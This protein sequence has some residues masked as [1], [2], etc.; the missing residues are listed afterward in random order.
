MEPSAKVSEKQLYE[1]WE[2]HSFNDKLTT[3]TGEKIT[4]ID[5]GIFDPDLSGPDFKNARIRIGNLMY[6]G[7]IE[8]DTNYNGWKAHGHN[9][10]KNFNKIILH[11]SL[12]NKFHQPF[13]YTK[14]GRKVPTACLSD[15][16]DSE[17]LKILEEKTKVIPKGNSKL[18]CKTISNCVEENDK[19]IVL[20][21]LARVRLQKKCDKIFHRLKELTYLKANKIGE[22][23]LHYEP[24]EAHQDKEF[25][26]KEFADRFIW[27]Q[28]FYEMVFEALGYSKNKEI[29]LNLA[30]AADLHFI[31]KLGNDNRVLEYIESALYNIGGIIPAVTKVKN[32]GKYLSSLYEDWDIIRR[33]YNGQTFSETDWYFFKHRPQNFPT[34]RIAGGAR[35]IRS[36]LYE[37]LVEKI[38]RKFVEIKNVNV[39]LNSIRSLFV[40]K[41]RGYWSDHYI[42]EKKSN[43]K[44]KYFVGVARANE[45]L[46]N[47]ILPYFAVYFDIF[48]NE[49]VLKKILRLY[50]ILEQKS[51][52]RI[53]KEVAEGIYM[54]RYTNSV[55]YT[56]G[57]LELFRSY[58]SKDKCLDCEIGKQLFD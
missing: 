48:K 2:N 8:I 22:P 24:D 57:M 42:F 55:V 7:D 44:I 6:V 46:V 54:E 25:D 58:C 18:K 52:N 33:I 36:I 41:A 1:L 10:D 35:I 23:V 38:V 53:V 50:N 5:V 9:I 20:K 30:K 12:F 32:P 39:L 27:N 3:V 56:Q 19:L 16:V 15:F 40:I 49:E 51:E 34:L 4:V 28:M 17:K 45:I 37:N 43:T 13:V 29:M 47:V 21:D 26:S 31:E 11:L 14:D